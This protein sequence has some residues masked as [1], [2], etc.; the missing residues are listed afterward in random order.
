MLLLVFDWYGT[1]CYR[2]FKSVSTPQTCELLE[3]LV[4]DDGIKTLGLHY[5][6]FAGYVV[7]LIFIAFI[8]GRRIIVY[9]GSLILT[10]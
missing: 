1:W 4:V 3:G 9:T 7:L 8:L 6:R 5:I 10:R 2:H